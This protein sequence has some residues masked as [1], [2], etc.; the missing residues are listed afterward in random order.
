[1][2][3]W[4]LSEQDVKH[5]NDVGDYFDFFWENGIVSESEARI[6]LEFGR[7]EHWQYIDYPHCRIIDEP[8]KY[9]N[10]T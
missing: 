3:F 2:S 7:N 6:L 4:V 9:K 8:Y 1:M 5:L 10:P